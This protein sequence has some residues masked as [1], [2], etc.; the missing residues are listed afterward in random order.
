[1]AERYLRLVAAQTRAQ[2]QYRVSFWIDVAGSVAFGLIDL[3]A[4]LVLYRIAPGL[5]GFTAAEAMLIAT[6]AATGFSLADLAVGNVER[7]RQYVRTGLLDAILI[8]PLG[9]LGQLVAVDFTPRRAGRVVVT[10]ILLVVSADA[11][12]VAWTPARVLLAVVAVAAGAVLFGSVFVATAA[13]SFWWTDVS[14]FANGFTYGGRD[15]TSFPLTIYR[16]PLKMLFGYVL[17]YAL[18]G[19]YPALAL[20]DRADPLGAPGWLW[21]AGPLCAVVAPVAAGLVWRSG[22]RHYRSTGS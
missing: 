16:G 12:N 10:A 18:V 5:G 9:V 20:L 19:Y 7:L 17:G 15:F 2:A 21:W 13:A 4:V 6:L 3:A 14:E 11:A 22:L 8:R 1:M